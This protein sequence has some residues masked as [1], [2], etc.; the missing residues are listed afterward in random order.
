MKDVAVNMSDYKIYED[1][2]HFH[3]DFPN[4]KAVEDGG[5]RIPQ[6]GAYNCVIEKLI[7]EKKTFASAFLPTGTGKTDVVRALAIGLTNRGYC[8]AVWVF[9]P[10]SGLKDQ[11]TDVEE[12]GRFLNRVGEEDTYS[13]S[14]F[15][16]EE[17]FEEAFNRFKDGAILQSWTTQKLAAGNNVHEFIKYAEKLKKETGRLPVGIIDECHQHGDDKHWGKQIKLLEE[18]GIS[19]ILLTGT[20][21]R[22]DNTAIPFFKYIEMSEINRPY[23]QTAYSS[24]GE[25]LSVKTGNL[26]GMEYRLEADYEFSYS[27]AMD[28]G[29]II[30]PMIQ[31]IDARETTHENKRLSEMSKDKAQ[32]HIQPYI[33]DDKTIAEAV[34]QTIIT[35]DQQGNSAALITTCADQDTDYH[36]FHAKKIKAEIKKQDPSKKVLIVTSHSE[37]SGLMEKFRTD[38]SYD[39][40]IVKAMGTIGYDCP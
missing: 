40:I 30:R 15:V 39:I 38:T 13:V 6:I 17:N 23:K 22:S 21:Y 37:E 31:Y 25:N 33:L 14:P 11:V 12:C 36:D 19:M 29:Y 10:N 32:K 35:L 8:S 28:E 3:E 20:P 24:F 9:S 7:V 16:S 4:A 5:P 27:R 34:S 26:V 1:M 18:A 2:R